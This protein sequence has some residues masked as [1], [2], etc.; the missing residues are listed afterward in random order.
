M[1]C[2]QLEVIDDHVLHPYNINLHRQGYINSAGST[3][4]RLVLRVQ[5]Y[6]SVVAE[7][8]RVCKLKFS[9]L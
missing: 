9:W 1:G 6:Y 7:L 5:A 2:G 4:I 8:C 3:S